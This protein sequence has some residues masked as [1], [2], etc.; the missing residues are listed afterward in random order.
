[1]IE[2]VGVARS[3]SAV[4]QVADADA[5]DQDRAGRDDQ[6]HQAPRQLPSIGPRECGQAAQLMQ[7][8]AAGALGARAGYRTVSTLQLDLPSSGQKGDPTI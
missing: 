1:M 8:R 5:E 7:V 2:R 4:D 3:E 6:G